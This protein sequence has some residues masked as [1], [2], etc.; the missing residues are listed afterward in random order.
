MSNRQILSTE[1]LELLHMQ[2]PNWTMTDGKLCKV[3]EFPD[4]RSAWAF[5][6]R[7]AE[8]AEVLDHHP[9][10]CNVYGRVSIKLHT[11]D[12]AGVTGLDMELAQKIDRL[13]RA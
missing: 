4:F 2:L 13:L 12:R 5:M 10:W 8:L 9:D 11:H 6:C 7:V 3:F 1:Q